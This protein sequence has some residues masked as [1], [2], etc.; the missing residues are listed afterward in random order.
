MTET[1]AQ[2]V[3]VTSDD[4]TR[5]SRHSDVTELSSTDTNTSLPK[6]WCVDKLPISDTNTSVNETAGLSKYVIPDHVNHRTT[7]PGANRA[8]SVN[9]FTP[10]TADVRNVTKPTTSQIGKSHGYR[11]T[12]TNYPKADKPSTVNCASQKL[13]S[14]GDIQEALVRTNIG[15]TVRTHICNQTL[16][17]PAERRMRDQGEEYMYSSNFDGASKSCAD[18]GGG[19]QEDLLTNC[20]L[21]SEEF[22]QG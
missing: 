14:Q 15:T 13:C 17:R 20:P 1:A 19:T 8:A 3:N 12:S 7:N 9:T 5:T 4:D 16:K 2:C 22:P 21:C 10:N 18:S 6:H 11:M